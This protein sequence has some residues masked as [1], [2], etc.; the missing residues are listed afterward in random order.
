MHTT[1]TV[2]LVVARK[3]IGLLVN[4]DNIPRSEC[5]TKSQHKDR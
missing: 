4:A 1:K 3:E 2:A 5:G